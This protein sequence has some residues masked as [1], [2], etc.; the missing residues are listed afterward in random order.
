MSKVFSSKTHT[1]QTGTGWS[2][3]FHY[4]TFDPTT[5]LL[6]LLICNL[7]RVF[8]ERVWGGLLRA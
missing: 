3:T 8:G 6:L 7:A 1:A 2:T 4:S 5:V